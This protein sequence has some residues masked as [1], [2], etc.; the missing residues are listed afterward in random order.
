MIDIYTVEIDGVEY[1]I[2]GDRPPTEAEARAAVGASVEPQQATPLPPSATIGM[3]APSTMQGDPASVNGWKAEHADLGRQIDEAPMMAEPLM[4]NITKVPGIVARVAGRSSVRAGQ[5]IQ[6]ASQAAKGAPV[7]VEKVGQE[8]LRALELQAAGGSMPRAASQFMRRVTDPKAPDLTFEEARDF[9]SNLSRLSTNE[10]GRLNPTMQRQI[11]TMR[12]ALHEA[13]VES[14]ET[15]GKGGQYARGISEYAKAA[16]AKATWEAS[17]PKLMS[18]LKKLGWLG[19]AGA[20]YKG[21]NSE[22]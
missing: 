2:E 14:A 15:V 10:F 5:N 22:P 21:L 16:K 12:Q 17:K 11:G 3:L 6:A 18:A 4:P 9:Y 1:D 13:L 20:G 7:N 8:G 19:L